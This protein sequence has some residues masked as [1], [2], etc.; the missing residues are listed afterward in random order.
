MI[1]NSLQLN[2][3]TLPV[4]PHSHLQPKLQENPENH[5]NQ[6]DSIQLNYDFSLQR[7]ICYCAYTT[8]QLGKKHWLKSTWK[9][10]LAFALGQ[11]RHTTLQRGARLIY[12]KCIYQ[13]ASKTNPQI[14]TYLEVGATETWEKLLLC[15]HIALK[16]NKAIPLSASTCLLGSC[17]R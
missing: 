10:A 12:G 5:Y 6:T 14:N 7:W 13:T 9:K 4:I 1:A 2:A 17:A 11:R 3:T 8:A 16:C 15:K